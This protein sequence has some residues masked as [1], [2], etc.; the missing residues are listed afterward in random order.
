MS[1]DVFTEK[2]PQQEMLLQ[3][4][5]E[6]ILNKKRNYHVQYKYDDFTFI[7]KTFVILSIQSFESFLGGGEQNV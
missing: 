3:S 2:K 6:N 7:G 1:M 4:H 5:Y